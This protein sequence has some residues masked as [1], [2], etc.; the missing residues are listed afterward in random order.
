MMPS[1]TAG[2][3]VTGRGARAGRSS[4][5]GRRPVTQNRL[6]DDEHSAAPVTAQHPLALHAGGDGGLDVVAQPAP[7][8]VSAQDGASVALVW[9]RPGTIQLLYARNCL[10]RS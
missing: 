7:L 10:V 4:P 2:Q 8:L 3:A 9:I 1:E 6:L 5:G